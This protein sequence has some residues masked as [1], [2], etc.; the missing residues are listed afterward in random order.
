[1]ERAKAVHS[2]VEGQ[3][4]VARK[5]VLDLM[6]LSGLYRLVPGVFTRMTRKMFGE[7]AGFAAV[8]HQTSTSV[9]RIDM[10][11]VSLS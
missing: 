4:I 9:W 1:M 8:E 10:T 5:M 2:M 6:R 3:A 7:A 11:Q